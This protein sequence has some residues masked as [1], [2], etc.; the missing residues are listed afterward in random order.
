MLLTSDDVEHCCC[1]HSTPKERL[2]RV[3]N[4][5][6]DHVVQHK[7]DSHEPAVVRA[8]STFA[9]YPGVDIIPPSSFDNMV[10]TT[11]QEANAFVS[12]LCADNV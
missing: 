5:T 6:P 10:R 12:F 8:S 9:K 1:S 11:G 4:T 2:A 7:K 3:E